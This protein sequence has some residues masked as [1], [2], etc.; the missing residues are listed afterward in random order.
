MIKKIHIILILFLI[1]FFDGKVLNARKFGFGGRKA[2]L[3]LENAEI[4]RSIARE[5]ETIRI[6][7][8]D[9]KLS[10][11]DIFVQCDYAEFYTE[12]RKIFLRGNVLLKDSVRI[13]TAEEVTYYEATGVAYAIGNVLLQEE[14][15]RTIRCRR[16][17]YDYDKGIAHYRGDIVIQDTSRNI[18]VTGQLG[19]YDELMRTSEIVV[20]PKLVKYDSAKSNPITIK[21]KTLWFNDSLRQAKVIEN[22]SVVQDTLIATGDY[23]FYDDSI[24]YAELTR[25]PKLKRGREV[26]TADTMVFFFQSQKLD[27]LKAFGN[28]TALAPA[29]T[30][31]DAPMNKITGRSMLS[32]FENGEA[33]LIIVTGNATSKYYIRENNQD[34]GI[35]VASGD[36]LKIFFVNKKINT[37]D[38]IGGVEGTYYPVGWK[39]E[40]E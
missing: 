19:S 26:M 38:V 40:V 32:Y 14:D 10:Q 2:P 22:V 18:V 16:L 24:G 1:L 20:E 13:L 6:L 33:K 39:G 5:D 31:D 7:I 12:S 34:S 15:H 21:G 30:T 23:L 8:N 4:L 17:E 11:E 25:N 28:V 29:D 9:V 37:I 3:V 36:T 35:N 27:Q